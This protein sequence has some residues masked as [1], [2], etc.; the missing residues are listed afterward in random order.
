MKGTNSCQKTRPKP[1]LT[2][3]PT[4]TPTNNLP[5]NVD[6]NIHSPSKI[7]KT[8]ALNIAPINEHNT[9][10]P[11]SATVNTHN[12]MRPSIKKNMQSQNQQSQNQQ[13]QNQQS[14]IHNQQQIQTHHNHNIASTV[15][16]S[17]DTNLTNYYKLFGFQISWSTIY[18]LIAF[19]VIL[20]LYF[21][22]KYFT[23]KP[24][25]TKK[26]EPVVSYNDQTKPDEET[27]D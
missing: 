19:V 14:Q 27:H 16:S 2:P 12:H 4:P 26:R 1:T 20:V 17:T 15:I 6:A 23:R 5:S 10:V 21:V 24:K 25:E 8:A 3:T 22:Y 11:T 18:I 9:C 13:S 7:P